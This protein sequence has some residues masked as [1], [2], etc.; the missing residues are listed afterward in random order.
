VAAHGGSGAPWRDT[1]VGSQRIPS[2]TEW[3]QVRWLLDWH[4][5][6]WLGA[7][8]GADGD[9]RVGTAE[10]PGRTRGSWQAL[11]A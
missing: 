2:P 5:H 10:M 9:D 7:A 3:T 8:V 6:P 11:Q 1:P 4:T